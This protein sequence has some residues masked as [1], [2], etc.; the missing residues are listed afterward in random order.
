[1]KNISKVQDALSGAWRK[2][3]LRPDAA[4]QFQLELATEKFAEVYRSLGS[5]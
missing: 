1:M 2:T 4:G 3:K 5:N